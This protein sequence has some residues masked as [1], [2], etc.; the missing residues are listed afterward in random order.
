MAKYSLNEIL[1]VWIPKNTRLTFN[2]VQDAK[3]RIQIPSNALGVYDLIKDTIEYLG[4]SITGNNTDIS[5]VHNSSSVNV[6]SSTGAPGTINAATT[7]LSGVMTAT[8]KINLNALG[9]L[10]GVSLG[11]TNLGSFTG[12]TIP[13]NVT[14]KG[15]LQALETTLETLSTTI[16]V[17]GNLTSSSSAITV[18]G[19]INAVNGTGTAINIIPGNILLSSLGG[20]LNLSQI[21]AG[22][23]S[24]GDTIMFDGTNWS[25]VTNIPVEHNGLGGLQ[26]G[27]YLHRYHLDI[28]LYNK[29]TSASAG[30]LIGRTT[31]SAGEVEFITPTNSIVLTTTNLALVNDLASPGNNKYYGTDGSGVKGW[32]TNTTSG[33]GIISVT[34]DLDIDFTITNPTTTPDITATLTTTGVTPGIYGNST[35]VPTI[36]VDAKGRI[37]NVTPTAISI[38]SSDVTNLSEAIDDRVSTLL[39][40]GTN[41]TLSY[42]DVANTLTI[43]STGGTSGSGGP[44]QVAYWD[45]ATGT[46]LVSSSNFIFDGTSL[47]I[48]TPVVAINSILTTKGISAGGLSWGY[49]H[50]DISDNIVFSVADNGAIAIG[51]STATPLTISSLGMEK[52]TG[53][54]FSTASGNIQL[55]PTGI[56]HLASQVG[57]NTTTVGSNKLTVSGGV[58]LNLGSD[59]PQDLLKRGTSGS[60]ERIPIGTDGDVLTIVSGVPVWGASGSSS[61]PAGSSGDILVHNGSSYVSASPITETQTGIVGT[62]VTLATAP[63]SFTQF[64]LYRNGV[65]QIITDDF[66]RVGTSITLTTALV[67]SDKITAIYYI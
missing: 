51:N 56:I 66:T 37:T 14:I 19:G 64:T 33:I 29:L 62:G 60:L 36:T 25:P 16:P 10:S 6:L 47:G 3:D 18:V 59:A 45:I 57:I 2:N 22:L 58:R 28:G 31:A 5:I 40:A 24:A 54:Y 38:S 32:H 44:A 1:G 7:L 35:Q 53:Y 12:T 46:S 39:V 49:S 41:I 13:N 9:T 23:A 43:N 11:S 17:T 50:L 34:D 15:A 48:N 27:T 52:D 63:L 65:Y 21:D 20:S 67:S 30:K 61:L 26:G 4:I 42:N 8:D 55:I